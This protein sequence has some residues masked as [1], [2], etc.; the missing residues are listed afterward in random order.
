MPRC[1]IAAEVLV[2]AHQVG[3]WAQRTKAGGLSDLCFD[4]ANSGC[5]TP[6]TKTKMPFP[7]TGTKTPD[8]LA[9]PD[10]DAGSVLFS[11][12][13]IFCACESKVRVIRVFEILLGTALWIANESY[14]TPPD[15]DRSPEKY[16]ALFSEGALTAAP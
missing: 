16:H 2:M 1:R 7:P 11:H 3:N 5:V 15:G 10:T 8:A 6:P 13:S 12:F 4:E 14:I 9:R